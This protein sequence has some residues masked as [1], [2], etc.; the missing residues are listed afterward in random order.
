MNNQE[1]FSEEDI[2]NASESLIVCKLKCIYSAIQSFK[3]EFNVDDVIKNF[4]DIMNYNPENQ[5]KKNHFDCLVKD[6][7]LNAKLDFITIFDNNSKINQKIILKNIQKN[8]PE[9]FNN[10]LNKMGLNIV[11]INKSYLKIN[12]KG[13]KNIEIDI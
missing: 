7:T 9:L 2:L 12:N 8:E 5:I 1:L 13:L 6:Y 3:K 4:D 11:D 10:F